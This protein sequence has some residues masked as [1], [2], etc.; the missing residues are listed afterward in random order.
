MHTALS[1]SV[2][3]FRVLSCNSR[4][5]PWRFFV[6]QSTYTL[7]NQRFFIW[8]DIVYC[9]PPYIQYT[10]LPVASTAFPRP[11]KLNIF[12]IFQLTVLCICVVFL[13]PA[14]VFAR[15]EDN[16]NYLDSLYYCFISL[17]TIGLGD[18]IPGDTP[19]QE[20][21]PLYKALTTCEYVRKFKEEFRM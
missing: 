14:L 8:Y 21:R 7:I 2:K 20:W 3:A 18:F 4:E 9:P 17:T 10:S 16:W 1:I 12:S 13:L 6:G 11:N 15:L 5:R 19:G